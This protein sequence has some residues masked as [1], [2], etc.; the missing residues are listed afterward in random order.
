MINHDRLFKELITTFFLEFIELFFPEVLAYIDPRSVDFLD[1]EIFTDVTSGERHEV[2]L[3][4]KVR[5][6]GTDAFFLIHVENQAQPQP[7]FHER[8]FDYFCRLRQKYRLPIYP[9]AL[10]TYEWPFELQIDRL[11]I[12]FPDRRILDF[13]FRVV[14]LNQLDWREFARRDNPV[15]SALM[16]KMNIASG[17]R[18]KVKLECIRLLSTFK[19]SPAKMHLIMG[20][21]DTYL[22]LNAEEQLEFQ[23]ELDELA[24]PQREKVMEVALSWREAALLEGLEQGREQ[25]LEQGREQGLEQGRQ[26]MLSMILRQ[27]GRRFGDIDA[28]IIQKISDL[29]SEGLEQLGESLFDIADAGELARWLQESQN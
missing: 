11:I 28:D 13:S 5:L 10:L 23:T 27:V 8:M 9:I 25:G 2:D 17:D 22:R 24:P 14:Q 29:D 6:A 12:D 19:L 1:K 3:V 18:P 15:A 4:A 26:R 16:A 7:D 21:V 20:L